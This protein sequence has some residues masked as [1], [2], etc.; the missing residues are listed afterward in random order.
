MAFK[1]QV[2][3]AYTGIIAA[4]NGQSR[5]PKKYKPQNCILRFF[6]GTLTD[7]KSRPLMRGYDGLHQVVS[8]VSNPHV[9]AY[10]FEA[11]DGRRACGV[12][13]SSI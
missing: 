1:S 11:F 4:F 10:S 9:V 13:C 2:F 5:Y 3:W 12:D 6:I 8:S 7:R